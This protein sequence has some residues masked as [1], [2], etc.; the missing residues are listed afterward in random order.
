MIGISS[1]YAIPYNFIINIS[2][3]AH[4]L[5]CGIFVNWVIDR[6]I[7]V[8]M[9][10]PMGLISLNE[11]LLVESSSSRLEFSLS[12]RAKNS[13]NPL[14]FSSRSTRSRGLERFF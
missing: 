9:V 5:H 13:A 1:H 8:Y 3:S 6:V 7:S 11:V 12:S 10:T 14:A 2:L 4:I